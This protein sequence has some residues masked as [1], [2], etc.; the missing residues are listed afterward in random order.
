[1]NKWY[2]ES[3]RF[4]IT[5]GAVNAEKIQEESDKLFRVL[6]VPWILENRQDNFKYKKLL[7]ILKTAP[8]LWE[9]W[10]GCLSLEEENYITLSMGFNK[11]KIQIEANP[12]YSW[13]YTWDEV[14]NYLET[15]EFSLPSLNQLRMI[16]LLYSNIKK[17]AWKN[18]AED[19]LWVDGDSLYWSS[20]EDDNYAYAV[21]FDTAYEYYINKN[22][23][24]KILMVKREKPI[25][26]I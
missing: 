10:E 8:V 21:C 18:L 1:M 4:W 5:E 16:N 19:F 15:D 7:E 13:F 17:E 14:I 25:I 24:A 22:K 20:T 11:E 26:K 6:S 12:F 23:K 2:L 9:I 3:V